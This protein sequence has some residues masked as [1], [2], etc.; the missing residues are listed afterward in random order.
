[1]HS[2]DVQI[3]QKIEN[4]I[5]ICEILKT[6]Q[7]LV[8]VYSEIIS[9]L[10]IVDKLKLICKSLQCEVYFCQGSIMKNSIDFSSTALTANREKQTRSYWV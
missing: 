7:K 4:Y 9:Y 2:K 10:K 8:Y 3:T 1:M 5:S 6:F